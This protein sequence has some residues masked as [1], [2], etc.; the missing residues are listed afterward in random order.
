MRSKSDVNLRFKKPQQAEL[1]KSQNPQV[2][3]AYNFSPSAKKSMTP[4]AKVLY[5][6]QSGGFSYDDFYDSLKELNAE[7]NDRSVNQIY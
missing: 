5:N 3:K 1:R 4:S 2:K 7:R 6:E